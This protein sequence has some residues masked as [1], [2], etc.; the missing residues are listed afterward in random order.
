MVLL[1][2]LRQRSVAIG[3]GRSAP[4]SRFGKRIPGGGADGRGG[5][6]PTGGGHHRIPMVW[7]RQPI[8]GVVVGGRVAPSLCGRARAEEGLLVHFNTSGKLA[9]I[10]T[11]K[12]NVFRL[13]FGNYY[14]S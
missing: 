12:E 1:R 14:C 7:H 4:K 13:A 10:W 8:N 9:P 2:M 11:E 5:G 6:G 3:I